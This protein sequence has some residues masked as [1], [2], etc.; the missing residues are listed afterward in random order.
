MG[1][2][3]SQLLVAVHD[4]DRIVDI[5][6]HRRRRVCLAGAIEI[7]QDAHQADEV[8]Q[9]GRSPN[10]RGWASSIAHRRCRA[11]ARRPA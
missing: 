9:R 5:E 7:D 8:A 2:E 1:V 10:A 6:G 4:L 11:A 3:P